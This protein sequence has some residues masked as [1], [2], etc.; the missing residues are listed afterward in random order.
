M[1]YELAITKLEDALYGLITD[2]VSLPIFF[3]NA[4]NQRPKTKHIQLHI[5]DVVETGDYH[6][7]YVLDENEKNSTYKEYEITVDIGCHQGRNT[8]ATL[9][10]LLHTMSTSSGLYYKYFS[11]NNIAYLRSSSVTSR[12]MVLDSVQYEERSVITMIFNIV[13]NMKDEEGT[14]FIE[15]VEIPT[16]TTI[17]TENNL[18]EDSTIITY[19]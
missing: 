13:V 3:R 4:S 2:S 9:L 5:G 16:L 6:S 14:G 19:P 11:E 17:V 12:D 15:T 8:R 10:T 18:V 1:S 7:D